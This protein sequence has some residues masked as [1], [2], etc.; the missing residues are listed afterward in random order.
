MNCYRYIYKC[1]LNNSHPYYLKMSDKVK[2]YSLRKHSVDSHSTQHNLYDAIQTS[3]SKS[4]V[5]DYE[6]MKKR[7]SRFM[8]IHGNEM[9]N[10]YFDWDVNAVK[11]LLQ[12]GRFAHY[13]DTILDE[14][15]K[16]PILSD[17]KTNLTLFSSPN[18]AK[19]PRKNIFGVVAPPCAGKSTTVDANQD[20]KH[21]LTLDG[22]WLIGTASRQLYGSENNEKFQFPES[23]GDHTRKKHM[24]CIEELFPQIMNK[25]NG[26]LDEFEQQLDQNLIS[27][28]EIKD[29]HIHETL[30]ILIFHSNPKIF[31]LLNIPL[32]AAIY[33]DK[34]EVLKDH[35][36]KRHADQPQGWINIRLNWF[37]QCNIQA[38]ASIANMT[39]S[40][41]RGV[42]ISKITSCKQ[43]EREMMMYPAKIRQ[44]SGNESRPI[45]LEFFKEDSVHDMR[46]ILNKIVYN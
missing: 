15:I 5:R 30:P 29:N 22:S 35:V 46:A 1:I 11:G 34:K 38:T 28:D 33:C 3:Q 39:Q 16:T 7:Y 17:P 10:F 24:K 31:Q 23:F 14:I 2:M 36:V 44:R 4:F 9:N 26:W 18:H 6:K 12:T 19:L 42:I 41:R 20:M 45:T 27:L 40:L 21:V 25:V 8:E 43:L 32:Y 13:T 37:Y